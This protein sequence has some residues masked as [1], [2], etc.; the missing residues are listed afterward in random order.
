MCPRKLSIF[1]P[2]DLKTRRK[3]KKPADFIAGGPYFL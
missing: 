3:S 2:A 1:K